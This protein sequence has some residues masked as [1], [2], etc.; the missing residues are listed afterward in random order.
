VT[1]APAA[2]RQT[3]PAEEEKRDNPRHNRRDNLERELRKPIVEFQR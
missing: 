2:P 1:T 3:N